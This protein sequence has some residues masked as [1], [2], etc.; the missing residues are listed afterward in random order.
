MNFG[1]KQLYIDGDLK[2]SSNGARCQV[3]CPGTQEPVAEVAWATRADAEAALAGAQAAFESWSKTSLKERAEWMALLRQAVI[4]KE[5]LL[6]L[7]VMYEMGKPWEATAEDYETVVNSLEWYAQE[8]QRMRDVNLPD[9]ENTHRHQIVS[10]PAGVAVAFL[11]WNFPLLNVGFKLGPALASG[12]TIILRPS[13]SSP[14]SAYVLGEICKEV[15]LPKGVVSV[16]CGPADEVATTLS[17]SPI[18]RIVTMIGSSETGRRLVAQSA[19][20]IK[21]LSMELGGNAPV[22]VFPDAD[23]EV[24]AREVA[25]LKFGNCGQICVSPNRIFVHHQVFERFAHLLHQHAC[26]VKVGFGRESN[27][28]MGPMIDAKSRERVHDI[29]S[30]A[31]RD[32]ARLLCGGEMP[33]QE[34]KG[35]F[36]PP[37][38][39]CDVR[40]DMRVA[41]EEVFGPVASL[42]EFHD[43]EA[44]VREAN[45]TEYGLV[46][47][48]YTRDHARAQM[49]AEQLEFG[50]VMING[51]KYAIYLPHGGIKES[52]IGKDCSQ[53]ALDDYLIKKRVTVKI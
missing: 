36:Y 41:R 48:A 35:F 11:A 23:I 42:I 38:I 18:P 53:F 22:L 49:L 31:V 10:Q 15:G 39:L 16:L 19:T 13:S 45:N 6:R 33:S 12:C 44:V 37:T 26:Q 28:T 52:G 1:Y 24:A 21:R 7:A 29:V 5:E 9:V 2:D 4:R 32:G 8:M 25:A 40:P 50:E 27:P 46:A 14:L 17:A 47:Y 3:I 30:D 43:E 20:S 51:F 34:Q